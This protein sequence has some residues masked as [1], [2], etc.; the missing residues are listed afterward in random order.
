[1]KIFPNY[2]ILLVSPEP[3]E[4]LRGLEEGQ[5]EIEGKLLFFVAA[6]DPDE[7]VREKA[8]ALLGS[9]IPPIS[10]IS[11]PPS[12]QKIE[13]LLSSPQELTC[14]QAILSLNEFKPG[15]IK[16]VFREISEKP[17]PAY[18]ILRKLR[19]KNE[20]LPHWFF[21]HLL[22][23]FFTRH[24]FLRFEAAYL[25]SR[26]FREKIFTHFPRLL[27]R[28]KDIVFAMDWLVLELKENP[29]KIPTV[30]SLLEP[31]YA[32]RILT[33][34]LPQSLHYLEY[35]VFSPSSGVRA[36]AIKHLT[37]YL[38]PRFIPDLF[39]LLTD[40]ADYVDRT[41]KEAICCFPLNQILPYCRF[42]FPRKPRMI[43]SIL[44]RYTLKEE[45]V[46]GFVSFLF[47]P[48]PELKVE[49][50]RILTQVDSEKFFPHVIPL[51]S[52]PNPRVRF[53]AACYL[54]GKT[55]KYIPEIFSS[56]PS[57]EIV[58][59]FEM[60]PHRIPEIPPECIVKKLKTKIPRK[61]LQVALERGLSPRW[62]VLV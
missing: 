14:L 24:S 5:K 44:S 2:Y 7:R 10:P 12:L 62:G 53:A 36:E 25:I 8:C 15:I 38:T 37:P 30:I 33:E 11:P 35:F 58:T 40:K 48:F 60:F 18:V 27:K 43:A 26:N 23:T 49:T 55:A 32:V 54:L 50:L 41:I 3:N 21:P 51:L 1:M 29:E 13:R 61:L 56:L 46:E 22:R 16:K 57:Q 19:E 4:R 6:T 31:Y 42:H 17:L 59:L 52:D 20:K 45:D 34:F 28:V 47:L 39:D 9:P